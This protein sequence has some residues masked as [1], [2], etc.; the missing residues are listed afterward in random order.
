MNN[1]EVYVETLRELRRQRCR[2]L[3]KTVLVRRRLVGRYESLK[4]QFALMALLSQ[5]FKELLPDIRK[6]F[7]G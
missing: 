3:E 1:G 4:E 5:K 6:I 2:N 7:F